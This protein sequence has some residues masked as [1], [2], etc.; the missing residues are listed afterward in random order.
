MRISFRGRVLLAGVCML[1]G[2]SAGAQQS[3]TALAKFKPTSGDVA[4][5]YAAERGKVAPGSCGC[6]W[7][8]GGGIDGAVNFARGIGIAASLTGDHASDYA[9]GLDISKVTFMAGPRYTYT[10]LT[11][12]GEPKDAKPR[13]Q[14][15]GQALFGGVH[16]FNSEFPSSSTGVKTSA[17]SFAMQTGAGV[18]L[19]FFRNFSARLLEAD[20]VRT[21]LPNSLADTQNDLRLSFGVSYHFTSFRLHR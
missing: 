12:H 17:G 8:E 6:F 7:Y 14:L 15:F 3:N 21:E 10:F 11:H 4:I 1:A 9:P 20:Y 18:N 19:F 5:T 16:A 2:M 13:F